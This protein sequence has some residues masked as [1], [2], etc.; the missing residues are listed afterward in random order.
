LTDWAHFR[1]VT[2]LD[3]G[4]MDRIAVITGGGQGIG[5]AAARELLQNGFAGV[6]L[7]DRNAKALEAV[8]GRLAERGRVLTVTADLLDQD[9]PRKVMA[10]ATDAFGRVDVLLNAAGNTERCGIED[11]TPEAYERLFNINVRAALFMMQ[12]AGKLM[13]QQGSGVVINIASMLSH[14]GPP[15]LGTYAA[16]KAAL[17]ALSK[18]AANTWKRHG[19]RVFA[20]NLGWVNS[21]GEHQLQVG[22]HN[23]PENWADL[24]GARMPAGRLQTPA[25]VAGLIAYL[26]SPSAQMMTGAVIDYEQ[27]PVGVFDQHPALATV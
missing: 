3:E 7:V 12:E 1:N 16:S 9:T 25:D 4:I 2:A 5:A 22:F 15:N 26:T 6:V 23:M 27:M 24:V 21:D 8:A 20:I 19:I 10:A 11:T 13:K 14:G 18:N 17:L